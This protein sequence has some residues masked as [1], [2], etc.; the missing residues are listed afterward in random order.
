MQS[1]VLQCKFAYPSTYI[2]H[3]KSVTPSLSCPT[4]T[5]PHRFPSLPAPGACLV[6]GNHEHPNPFYSLVWCLGTM[7]HEI[8]FRNSS[9]SILLVQ[10]QASRSAEEQE[11]WEAEV[12]SSTYLAL[13]LASSSPPRKR[14]TGVICAWRFSLG[15]FVH[16]SFSACPRYKAVQPAARCG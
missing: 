14:R 11:A 1:S 6:L 8:S 10:A 2:T 15:R 12:A 3:H 5:L 16:G 9:T 7:N 13:A 4:P